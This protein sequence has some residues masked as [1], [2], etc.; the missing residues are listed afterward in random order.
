MK[1]DSTNTAVA[2]VKNQSKYEIWYTPNINAPGGGFKKFDDANNSIQNQAKLDA[3][4]A[5]SF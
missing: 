4:A 3:S 1:V 2:I 5:T